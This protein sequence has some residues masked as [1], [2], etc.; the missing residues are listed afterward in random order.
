MAEPKPCNV[1]PVRIGAVH[2][3]RRDGMTLCGIE[4]KS[5]AGWVAT[6][7]EVTCAMCLGSMRSKPILMIYNPSTS[8]ELE[9]AM[10]A[11]ELAESL[12]AENDRLKKKLAGLSAAQRWLANELDRQIQE[13]S[14]RVNMLERGDKR[15]LA[16]REATDND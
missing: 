11:E 15:T 16:G 6:N 2:A 8:P 13:L 10:A 9:R 1:R 7:A 4:H 12:G 5:D 14:R 3:L